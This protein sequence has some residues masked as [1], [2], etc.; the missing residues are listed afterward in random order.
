MKNEWLIKQR[1]DKSRTMP[2]LSYPGAGLVGINV[3]E[4]VTSSDNQVKAMKAIAEKCPTSAAVNLMDLSVE[5]EAFGAEIRFFDQEIP[6]VIGKLMQTK[7]NAENLAVP[8][9]GQKRDGLYLQAVFAASKL[10]TD[11]PIFAGVI[12]PFSLAG[13]LMGMTDIMMDCY[14]DP[15]KVHLLL[16]KTS[17][18]LVEYIKACK[19]A[20]AGGILMAEPA[21]GL[22]SPKLCSEFS[23]D[24]IK[25]IFDFV[26]GDDLVLVYHN[27]GN[28]LPLARSIASVNADIY[29]FGNA[30]DLEE[31]IKRMP[32]ERLI[33]GNLDSY[34]VLKNGTPESVGKATRELL[35]RC[36]KYENFVISSGCDIPPS[37]P[38]DNLMAYFQAIANF[39][40]TN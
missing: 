40:K 34:G 33:M 37:T 26:R 24:Y 19:Q 29:H 38:W 23:S 2:I 35:E 11:R 7:L 31:M 13:R 17:Q 5:A 27:C 6:T 28:V 3:R 16:R 1:K 4:L 15:D 39:Y 32:K 30:V 10:I 22:L 18:Y 36:G 8:P 12:G 14:D 25:E 21:A 20:G 9:V